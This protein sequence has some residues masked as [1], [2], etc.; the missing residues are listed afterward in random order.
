MKRLLLVDDE[1]PF[2]KSMSD[3]LA[4]FSSLEVL[5]AHTGREAT[6]VLNS[7]PIDLV[8]TDMQMPEMGG[9]ELLSYVTRHHPTLPVMVMTAFAT[10]STREQILGLGALECFDKPIDFDRFAERIFAVLLDQQRSVVRS[11]SV[12]S[13]LQLANMER[14]S[15][16]LWI[17]RAGQVGSLVLSEGRLV[18]AVL[19]D[20]VGNEAAFKIIGWDEAVIDIEWGSIEADCNVTSEL[21]FIIMEAIRQADEGKARSPGVGGRQVGIASSSL[22]SFSWHPSDPMDLGERYIEP[23]AP[24]IDSGNPARVAFVENIRGVK[25]Y[26]ACSILSADGV[27]L[28]LDSTDPSIDLSR[29][30]EIFDEFFRAIDDIAVGNGFDSIREIVFGNPKGIVIMRCSGVESEAHF[31]VI[32]VLGADGNQALAR[33]FLNQLIMNTPGVR[34]APALNGWQS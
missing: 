34:T 1:Q 11:I 3:G 19:G 12:A 16:R 14:V 4:A 29:V 8:V 27:P 6:R 7:V 20:R 17:T 33:H 15:C 32:T 2:L 24:T 21:G 26:K 18:H 5:T 10:P 13:F 9:M 31:H 22:R 30:K 23:D 25:G 28:V